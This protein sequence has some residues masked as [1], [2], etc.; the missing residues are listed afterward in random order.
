[1]RGGQ[2]CAGGAVLVTLLNDD[3]LLYLVAAVKRHGLLATWLDLVAA[4]TSLEGL[5]IELDIAKRP[6]GLGFLDRHCKSIWK[7]PKVSG[8]L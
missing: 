2:Q 8:F 7:D 4:V 3:S 6:F 5:F 1:M